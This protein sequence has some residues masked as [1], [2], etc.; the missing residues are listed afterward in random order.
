MARGLAKR[1]RPAAAKAEPALAPA[2]EEGAPL[3]AGPESEPKHKYH[4]SALP[5]DKITLQCAD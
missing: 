4:K 2:V 3:E 1:N 5:P